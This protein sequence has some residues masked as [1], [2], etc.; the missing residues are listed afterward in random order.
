MSELETGF[1]ISSAHS[2]VPQSEQQALSIS[3]VAMQWLLEICPC[4]WLGNSKWDKRIDQETS[5]ARP[6]DTVLAI[7]A[8]AH[9]LSPLESPTRAPPCPQ[10]EHTQHKPVSAGK[11]AVKSAEISHAQHHFSASYHT[12]P[13]GQLFVGTGKGQT[14]ARKANACQIPHCFPSAAVP[15]FHTEKQATAFGGEFEGSFPELLGTKS[16]RE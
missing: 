2:G 4:A 15:G 11:L 1:L 14:A 9:K 10:L 3:P 6:R 16:L 8:D 12:V 7:E 5:F 13:L